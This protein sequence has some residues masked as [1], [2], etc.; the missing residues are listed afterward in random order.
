M[1][2]QAELKYAYIGFLSDEEEPATSPL[3]RLKVM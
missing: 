2:L 1:R 3:K